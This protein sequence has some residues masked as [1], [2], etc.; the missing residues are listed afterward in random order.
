MSVTH[1]INSRT[2]ASVIS[3][4]SSRPQNRS[5]AHIAAE[6]LRTSVNAASFVLPGLDQQIRITVSIGV[7]VCCFECLARTPAAQNATRLLKLADDAL[8]GSKGA[9]R[10]LVTM[11]HAA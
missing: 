7:A 8:Y 5:A 9:G 11:V 1:V 2:C 4:R 3:G 6:R 10:N